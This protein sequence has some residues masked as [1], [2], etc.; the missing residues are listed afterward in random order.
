MYAFNHHLPVLKTYT[1]LWQV[2]MLFFGEGTGYI[3]SCDFHVPD[4]SL[5]ICTQESILASITQAL[6]CRENYHNCLMAVYL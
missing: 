4:H 2:D 5:H 3:C 1:E 6:L